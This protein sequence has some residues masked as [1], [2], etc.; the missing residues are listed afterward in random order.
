MGGMG[1]KLEMAKEKLKTIIRK[2]TPMS[3]GEG[4]EGFS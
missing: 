2:T 1:E 4:W 3:F